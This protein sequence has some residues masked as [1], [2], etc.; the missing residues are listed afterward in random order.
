[1][2]DNPYAPKFEDL[3]ET[4]AIFPLSGA[5][6]LP[7]G[8]LPL[9]IFEPRYLA[10]VEEAMRG[11]RMIGM[12]QPKKKGED[13]LFGVGCAG[14]ITEFSETADGRYLISLHGICRFDIEEEL[15]LHGGGFRR[16]R[17]GWGAYER[18]LTPK[19]CLDLNREKLKGLLET[20]FQKQQMNCDWHKIDGASDGKLIT[21]L[22]M[23]CP[24][25]P[26]EK[27][28]L[29]EAEC[30]KDRADKFMSMLEMECC[31]TPCSEH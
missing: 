11:S 1:M 24:L 23:V 10:M 30:G 2:L 28:A 9:N 17:P 26:C 27:Q 12:I 4:L 21:C 29:L 6:L 18:D 8:T 3:P 15:D 31:A 19:T 20:Y 25:T 22:S 7:C 5:L 16:V 13:A 14:K